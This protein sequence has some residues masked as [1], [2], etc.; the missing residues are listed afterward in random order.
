VLLQRDAVETAG[1]RTCFP[2]DGMPSGPDCSLLAVA[3]RPQTLNP[4]LQDQMAAFLQSQGDPAKT[5]K[6]LSDDGK[7][8]SMRF[9]SPEEEIEW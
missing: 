8:C 2:S 4:K 1:L 6:A 7:M 3:R 9:G 5:Q